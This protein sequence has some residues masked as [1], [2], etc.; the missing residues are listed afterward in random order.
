MEICYKGRFVD[1]ISGVQF[2]IVV[3][4]T[5]DIIDIQESTGRWYDVFHGT[6]GW[7]WYIMLFKLTYDTRF[8]YAN[9]YNIK[10]IYLEKG[11][12]MYNCPNTQS[13]VITEVKWES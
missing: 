12:I 1:P 5:G 6:I 2:N 9:P 3:N 4:D 11:R 10:P 7:I 13:A 8:V